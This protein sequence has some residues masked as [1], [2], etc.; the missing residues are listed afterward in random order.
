[1]EAEELKPEDNI[2]FGIFENWAERN[3]I[4]FDHEEDWISFW[5]T[6]YDGFKSGLE[7]GLA[8][9]RIHD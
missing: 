4:S 9:E 1:M 8:K 7:V 6:W 3:C 5:E 2:Y